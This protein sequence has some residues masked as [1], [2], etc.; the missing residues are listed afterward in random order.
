MRHISEADREALRAT[1][2]D[3]L[4]ELFGVEDVRRPFS[5]PALDHDDRTPSARYYENG[6]TVH[7]FGCQRTWDVFPLVG[8]V[9]GIEG[10]A[11]QAEAVAEI[12]GYRLNDG[13]IEPPR[14]KRR[15]LRKEPEP[16]ADPKP[17]GGPDVTDICQRAYF[18]LYLPGCEAGRRWLRTRGLGDED[19]LRHGLGYCLDPRRIMGQ[20]GVYE[21]EAQGFVVIPFWSQ[22]FSH[23]NYAMLRTVSRGSARH[24]EWRPK[25]VTSPL[26]REWMLSAG[27]PVVYV[28]EG[29][30]DAMALEKI[31]GK[32]VMALG[33]TSYANRLAQ[34]LWHTE[35]SLRPR[36]IV[37]AMD[38][39]LAGRKARD[40]IAADLDRIGVRHSDIPAYP[41]GCKDADDWLMAAHGTEW[42]WERR[43]LGACDEQRTIWHVRWRDGR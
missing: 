43:G 33:G 42:E 13:G 24:K 20:F 3:L 31:V 9:R 2:P 16:F 25:G 11:A 8:E 10:F 19:I 41:Q 17:A 15:L 29:L 1:M 39:D 21:P 18:N 5:C 26:Y 34:V 4:Y 36:R 38:A 27:L 6:H 40:K 7:C 22:D 23:C 32:P 14:P 30:I 12:V 35:P 28:T 37:I